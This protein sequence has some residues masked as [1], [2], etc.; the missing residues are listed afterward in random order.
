MSR[1]RNIKPGFFK[2]EILVELAFEYRLLFI[3]L[4]TMADRDGRL[5]DR[6]TKI[7]MEVFPADG[8]DVNAGLQAL[9]DAGFILRYDVEGKAFIQILAW[10]KHQNPHVKEA[11]STIPAPDGNSA[12]TVQVPA[13]VD[14][15]PADSLIPDSLIPDS[16][17]DQ[18]PLS[19]AT[20]ST[21]TE[22][23]PASKPSPADLALRRARRLSTITEDAIETYNR[24]M[25][26][27]NGRL[28]SVSAKVG[29]KTRLKQVDRS[30][31]TASEICEDQFSDKKITPEFWEMYFTACLE[32]DFTSGVGPY[33][34][35]HANWRPD[36]EYLTRPATML[37]IFERATNQEAAA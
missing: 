9:H 17:E 6:P 4:W 20:P 16:K 14:T 29:R 10:G 31:Q 24:L 30:L 5:E 18:P 15:S 3:G 1:A 7:R 21:A 36:F 25:G 12:S 28:A 27:P 37:K 13:K 22:G 32:D 26:K 11:K 34:G 2:N 35:Q 23:Q 19:T 33:T 8:V